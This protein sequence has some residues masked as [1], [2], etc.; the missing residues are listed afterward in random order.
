L[1]PKSTTI[2]I[3]VPQGIPRELVMEYLERCRN[4]LLPLEAAVNQNQHDQVRILGHRMKGTGAPYGFSRLTEIGAGIEQAAADRNSGA[5]RQYV[6]EL[7]EYL[8]RVEI[9]GQ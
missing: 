1:D 2:L 3:G 8:S 4:G 7:E 6:S 5:L 9:A